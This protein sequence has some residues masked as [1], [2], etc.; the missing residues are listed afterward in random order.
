MSERVAG[1]TGKI[2]S[3]FS[4][5]SLGGSAAK[6]PNTPNS[7][8]AHAAMPPPASP[9]SPA[10][11]MRAEPRPDCASPL[12]AASPLPAQKT[13]GESS[14][15]PKHF[16]TLRE[17]GD[18][19][20]D[21]STTD[22][23]CAQFYLDYKA[24]GGM[25]KLRR[26]QEESNCKKVVEWFDAFATDEELAILSA[27]PREESK[28]INA[29]RYIQS[30]VIAR[31]QKG[32]KDNHESK[33]YKQG[34]GKFKINTFENQ[35]RRAPGIVV[36]RAVF[37]AFRTSGASPTIA[38]A[39]KRTASDTDG[40]PPAPLAHSK[41]PRVA[42]QK[43]SPPHAKAEGPSADEDSDEELFTPPGPRELPSELGSPKNP[44]IL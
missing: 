13:L 6:T 39:F 20:K 36:S 7:S 27:R 15:A 43:D 25:P 29:A 34:S 42:A 9:A 22:V 1:L 38:Q 37:Q 32:Q 12:N 44:M 33:V 31:I 14:N 35:L 5:L 16:G 10:M 21:Y 2:E 23:S 40:Q 3:I 17:M 11:P 18:E 28:A 41:A 19:A 26:T 24:L 30:T 8:S 4:M